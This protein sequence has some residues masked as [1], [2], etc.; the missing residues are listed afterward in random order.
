LLAVSGLVT[1][2][3]ILWKSSNK[4]DAVIV[5]LARESIA[6]MKGVEAGTTIGSQEHREIQHD[7]E[8]VDDKLNN[9]LVNVKP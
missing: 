4:K 3:I 2:I 7:L 6:A 5:E 9:I 8:R 1:G